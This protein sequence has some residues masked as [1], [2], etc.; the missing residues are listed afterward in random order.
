MIVLIEPEFHWVLDDILRNT[1]SEVSFNPSQQRVLIGTADQD[2][3]LCRYILND[4]LIDSI[5]RSIQWH[6]LSSFF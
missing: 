6:S 2:S 4:K 5:E 3:L 1:I